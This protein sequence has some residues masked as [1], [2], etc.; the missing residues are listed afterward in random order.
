MDQEDKSIA[1]IPVVGVCVDDVC[2]AILLALDD[3]EVERIELVIDAPGAGGAFSDTQLNDLH[4]H[5][6]AIGAALVRARDPTAPP[7]AAGQRREYLASR[8]Q[9]ELLA[10]EVAEQLGLHTD[11]V[12]RW[13]SEAYAGAVDARL[14]DVRRDF[15]GRYWIHESEVARLIEEEKS[16]P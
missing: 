9:G 4:C 10:S 3:D 14:H 12:R 16:T 5:V 8:R 11:T 2:D 15:A 1:K 13:A 7:R 6:A